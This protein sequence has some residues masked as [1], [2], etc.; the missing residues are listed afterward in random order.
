VRHLGGKLDHLGPR[1]K[2]KELDPPKGL[3]EQVRK[4][5][6]G[7][8]LACLDAPFRQT[9]SDEVVP[10]SDVPPLFME[11]EV[12][13]QGQSGLVVHPEFHHSSVPAEEITE[14]S[15]SPHKMLYC[16]AIQS[17]MDEVAKA[18]HK[19]SVLRSVH[20]LHR[21]VAT[22]LQLLHRSES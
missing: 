11:N 20:L 14:Q 12:L 21:D 3:S 16:H 1:A 17:C 4:L 19:M 15:K 2:L 22:Q 13:R 5:V 18:L 9:V 8:D 10:N 7:D 6:V